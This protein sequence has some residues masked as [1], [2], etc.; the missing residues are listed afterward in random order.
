MQKIM[1]EV[2]QIKSILFN[3]YDGKDELHTGQVKRQRDPYENLKQ[4]PPQDT[5]DDLGFESENGNEVDKYDRL[6]KTNQEWIDLYH[7]EATRIEKMKDELRNDK[8]VLKRTQEYLARDQEK[9]KDEYE[10]FKLS[11][12]KSAKKKQML[13]KLR[14][15]LNEQVRKL[16]DDVYRLRE[17]E[18]LIQNKERMLP[19]FK[20]SIK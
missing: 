15:T 16:N 4:I 10:D 5:D 13:K 3:T 9:F 20:N 17:N 12:S 2:T 8:L 11:A 6:P 19:N 18:F 7:R 1:K 14:K